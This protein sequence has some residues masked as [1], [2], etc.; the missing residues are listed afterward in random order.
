MQ[1]HFMTS[2]IR[3]FIGLLLI[4]LVS[5]C[6]SGPPKPDVDYN[7]EFNFMAVKTIA[8]YKNSGAVSG[9]NPLQLSD[10]QRNR[11]DKALRLALENKGF[12]FIEDA[13]KA[14]LLLSWHLSTQNKTDVRTYQSPSY[15][16]GG[17]G[18]HYG[19][20]NRYSNYNCWSCSS[21]H[22]EV[23][24]KEYTQGTFIVDIIDPAAQQSV[25]RGV[26]QSKLKGNKDDGQESY[27]EAATV[28]FE[29]FPP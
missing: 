20:Y 16:Y 12:S 10:M 24:V 21:G 9:D 13:S 22:T 2:Q 17:Y 18:G 7:A 14:D 26:T 29:S 23:S 8:F 27:N 4:A 15:G 28:I 1:H 6:S 3:A 19:G 5:A 25:W 11:A